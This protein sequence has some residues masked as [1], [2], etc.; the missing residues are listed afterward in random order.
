MKPRCLVLLAAYNGLAFIEEQVRSILDQQGVDVN[1]LISVD[2]SSDGTEAWVDALAFAEPRVTVLPHGQRFGGAGANF[3][4]L[5]KDASFEGIDYVSLADQDDIW[6]SDKLQHACAVLQQR[7]VDGYSSDVLAFWPDGREFVVKKS[8]PQVAHDYLFEAA[9]P[10]CTY[11]L[12]HALSS[13]IQ[14][15]LNV[16]GSAMKQVAL[17]DWF[18]YAFSRANGF[19]WFIDDHVG[20]RYRQHA[21]NQVGVNSGFTAFKARLGKVFDGWWLSQARVIAQLT[22]LKHDPFVTQW[23]R[24]DRRALVRLAASS[25]SCRRRMRDKVVFSLLCLVLA[26]RGKTNG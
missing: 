21:T 24:L 14:K 18:I 1:I 17:H 16:N 6:L 10:G 9:G 25:G 20:M 19:K 2:K 12:S 23:L 4:R 22:G 26:I 11:V 8:Q 15:G 7:K 13:A 3:F 5:I